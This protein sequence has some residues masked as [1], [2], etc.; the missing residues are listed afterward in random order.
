MTALTKGA[1]GECLTT[2]KRFDEAE[3][4]LVASYNDLKESQGE[5]TP[6]TVGALERLALLYQAWKKPDQVEQYRAL[7]VS[8]KQ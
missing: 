6:R 2:Q 5:Q 8:A 3:S 1:L 4:L 7:L